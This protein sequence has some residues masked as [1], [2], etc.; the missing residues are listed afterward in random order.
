VSFISNGHIEVKKQF[1]LYLSFTAQEQLVLRTLAVCSEVI[2]QTVLRKILAS[3]SGVSA[4]EKHCSTNKLD[5]VFSPDFRDLL[6]KRKLVSVNHKGVV[7]SK[8]LIHALTMQCVKDGT[9]ATIV[10]QIETIVPAKVERYWGQASFDYPVRHFH[11]NLYLGNFDN[12]DKSIT[13]NKNPQVLDFDNGEFLFTI[14]FYP[15]SEEFFLALP[16]NIQY[17]A[18]ALLFLQQQL[19][20]KDNTEELAL[21]ASLINKDLCDYDLQLLLAEQFLL[22]GELTNAKNII[23]PLN[24]QLSSKSK[25]DIRY[26][27]YLQALMGWLSF[28]E[29]DFTAALGYFEQHKLSKNKLTRRKRQYVDG[30]AGIFYLFT[31]LKL[32][33]EGNRHYFSLIIEQHFN[34]ETD[35]ANFQ[36]NIH[37]YRTLSSCAEV[38]VGKK[39]SLTRVSFN[40]NYSN[41]LFDF[42]LNLLL[43]ALCHAWLGEAFDDEYLVVLDKHFSYL[44][45]SKNALLANICAQLLAKYG[46]GNKKLNTEKK[47]FYQRFLIEQAEEY[48]APNLLSLIVPKEKWLTA[49]EQLISLDDSQNPVK[50]ELMVIDSQYRLIW[51]VDTQGQRKIEPR[52]QKRNK[53]GWTKG[54]A[55]A[56]QRLSESHEEFPYLTP[57]DIKICQAIDIYYDDYS[58]NQKKIFDLYGYEALNAC[59]GH[60]LLFIDNL[61]R[62]PLDII[63]KTPELL[64]SE[65]GRGYKI[66]LADIPTNVE[67]DED[68][69]SFCSETASRYVLTAF[70]NKLVEIAKIVGHNGLTIPVSAKEKVIQSIKA[71]APLLNIQTNISGIEGID[72]GIEQIA[73]DHT[74]YINIEPAGAGLQFECHVQP[75]GEQGPTL[76]PGVGNAMVVGLFDDKRVGT[77]R[78][79]TQEKKHFK[80]LVDAC[81]MFNYMSEHVLVLDELED[82]LGCLEHLEVLSHDLAE[83]TIEESPI[84]ELLDDSEIQDKDKSKSKTKTKTKTKSKSKKPHTPL[85][86]A[87]QWPEGKSLKVSKTLSSQQMSVK[88]NKTQ[89]WFDLEGELT[90]DENEVI[91]MKKLITLVGSAKGRFIQLSDDHFI[92]LTEGLKKQLTLLDKVSSNGKFDAL[93]SPV[94]DEALSGMQVKSG[95]AWQQQMKK[96]A[97]SYKLQPKVPETLQAQLRDYQVEGYDW[98]SRLSHWGAGACLADDM[99]LGKTLQALAIIVERASKGPTLVLA[100]TSVS[101]NWQDEAAK[102]SPTLNVKLYGMH[103]QQTRDQILENAQAFDLIICSYGLLQTQ[104]EKLAKVHWRTLIADEAQALKNP[105]TKRSKIANTLTADFK[106]IT[107][108]T[109]IENNLTDL[110]SLFRFINPRLL[111]S[112][113]QFN[114]RF[115]KSIENANSSKTEGGSSK[116][117][118][119]KNN[120]NDANEALR[121]IIAPFMLRR[122]KTDVLT[123]LPSRTEIN[124]HVELSQEESALYEAIR[125]KALENLMATND[126]PGQKRI[127]VLA[128]IMRLRRACCHPKLV[129]E[130]SDIAGSK[131]KAFDNLVDELRQGGH[132]AL[133]FSQFVGH[134]AILKQHLED[135]GISFQYLDGST[136]LAKRKKAVADFQAGVG[137]LFLIS[138]KAGGSGLNLTAADYVIHMDPWWNPAVEDQASDRAHRMGQTRPVTIYRLITQHTI[139]DKIV[140]LHQQKRELANSLLEGTGTAKA[141]SLDDMMDLL[142][143]DE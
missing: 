110:W 104:G 113:K 124:I 79:L 132:K 38:F 58:W 31:L 85:K 116:A 16:K 135:K 120:I 119:N 64:I 87:L 111:G 118:V 123:E 50:E 6:M 115:V 3:F 34:Y 10:E 141:I 91:D 130:E 89:D 109:P 2:G 8:H 15:F 92:A 101:F 55:V 7:L 40:S 27:A 86:I 140:A 143:D 54:R 1:K 63:E 76:L 72:T 20:Q 74:L 46:V 33:H 100:P 97:Q 17:Q 99:G 121:K 82:A 22:R 23:E 36:Q 61:Q 142:K 25:T 44:Q 29:K 24:E 114:E 122:L 127:K 105:Q 39:E 65:S 71:I 13:F 19:A 73:Q 134:L 96:L 78:V 21:L 77:T 102:F 59:I 139:E 75:L 131:L 45:R 42:Q 53:S 83:S 9:L 88:V 37:S 52:E 126:K 48:I 133:V 68:F 70:K 26:F 12:L 35:K 90:I 98:A 108:G 69:Y 66:S 41:N 14:C 137:D 136:S 106:M 84:E 62:T 28:L 138:L 18:F 51:L 112:L 129:F 56:L 81:P 49:L 117:E 11:N 4:F 57:A 43:S 93:A 128:E 32:G 47:A 103:N 95:K 80:M 107:T 67:F 125:Q 94:I 5:L 60:P 30:V